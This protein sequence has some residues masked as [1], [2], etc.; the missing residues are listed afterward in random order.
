MGDNSELLFVQF[1]F[2]ERQGPEVSFALTPH[3]HYDLEPVRQAL[4]AEVGMILHVQSHQE[5]YCLPALEPALIGL[6]ALGTLPF[7]KSL[8]SL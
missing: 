7:V 4:L 8:P 1:M 5:G 6:R 2:I 3:S